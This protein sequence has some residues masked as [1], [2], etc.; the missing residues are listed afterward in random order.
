MSVVF[1]RQCVRVRAR[2]CVWW[3]GGASISSLDICILVPFQ[4]KVF[5]T[6]EALMPVTSIIFFYSWLLWTEMPS[7]PKSSG[8]RPSN[9]P[10]PHTRTLTSEEDSTNFLYLAMLLWKE[11]NLQRYI[12]ITHRRNLHNYK[13]IWSC[14]L[15]HCG[16]IAL[17]HAA[18][19]CSIILWNVNMHMQKYK[20]PQ[21]RSC[22]TLWQCLFL[23][24]AQS[25]F[26]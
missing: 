11:T 14:M 4:K 5:N 9:S 6:R 7:L 23:F 17:K 13:F 25:L 22:A 21:A 15:W 2:A 12:K 24:A 18:S 8:R 10:G 19:I 3:W 20:G 26:Y 1:F 16:Y